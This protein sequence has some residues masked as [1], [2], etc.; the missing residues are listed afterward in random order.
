MCV[1]QFYTILCY[2]VVQY[3]VI[4]YHTILYMHISAQPAKKSFLLFLYCVLTSKD[5]SNSSSK[6]NTKTA[7]MHPY[8]CIHLT[9]SCL[10][11]HSFRHQALWPDGHNHHWAL[12]A[13]AVF[14]T[15]FNYTPAL[16]RQW[17]VT[18]Y[19]ASIYSVFPLR[20][21]CLLKCLVNRQEE[22]RRV[23]RRR[24]DLENSLW[25]YNNMSQA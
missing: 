11:L 2:I 18:K 8:I 4:L 22:R 17:F 23:M 16:Q 3:I 20:W 24:M 6:S 7:L 14:Q 21:V 5:R 13:A 1:Q 10:F 15:A 9:P 19:R 12:L 25:K